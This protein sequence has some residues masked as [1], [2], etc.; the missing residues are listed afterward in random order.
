MITF[1]FY[2][3]LFKQCIATSLYCTGFAESLVGL[4]NWTHPWA[5]RL[6]SIITLL[7]LVGIALSG[8]KWIV[9]FQL[10]LIVILAIAI[11]DYLIGTLAQEKPGL[12]T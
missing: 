1:F 5:I 2:Y 6:I 9:R 3:I 12:L 4:I 7:V 8:V 11:C 10:V